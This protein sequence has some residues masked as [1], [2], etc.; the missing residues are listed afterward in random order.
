MNILYI[1]QSKW[2][3]GTITFFLQFVITTYIVYFIA[4]YDNGRPVK[5]GQLSKKDTVYK[6]LKFYIYKGL[7]R[8]L[9][10]CIIEPINRNGH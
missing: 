6:E 4:K 3:V 2:R 5:K 1:I 9:T 7:T 8:N 10:I